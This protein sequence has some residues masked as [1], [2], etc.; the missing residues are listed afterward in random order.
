MNKKSCLGVVMP[1]PLGSVCGEHSGAGS[2]PVQGIQAND[3]GLDYYKV[4]FNP[5]GSEL[6]HMCV[7]VILKG[8]N[9]VWVLLLRVISELG[10]LET[11]RKARH[12]SFYPPRK[13]SLCRCFILNCNSPSPKLC[14]N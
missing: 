13:E 12:F 5:W 1:H 2:D 11:Q 9:T 10:A 4:N 14:N 3:G 7:K 6:Q 8:E